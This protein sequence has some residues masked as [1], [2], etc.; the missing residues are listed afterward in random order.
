MSTRG[1]EEEVADVLGLAVHDLLDEVVHDVPV[2]PGEPGDEPGGVVAALQRQRGQLQRGH[3]ALGPALQRGHVGRGEPESHRV[4]VRRRLLLGE[5]KV[6]RAHLGQLA[7]R[8]QPRQR[9]RRVGAGRD[10]EP[11]LGRQVVDAGTPSPRGS[12]GRGRRGSRR[13]RARPRRPGDARS[14]SRLVSTVVIGVPPGD[15]RSACADPPTAGS[16]RAE[17]GQHVGPEGRRVAVT[18]VQGQPRHCAPCP[19]RPRRPAPGASSVDFPKPAGAETRSRAARPRHRAG[20]P[21]G[22][23][24]AAGRRGPASRGVRR[25]W[26]AAVRRRR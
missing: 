2:V 16:R 26:S 1:P 21:A 7:A 24:T 8:A 18:G 10:H 6:G 25:A 15:S 5:P 12:P 17:G 3:P 11:Q 19:V 22:R 13:G 9:Q 14:L 23:S 20:H 4:E